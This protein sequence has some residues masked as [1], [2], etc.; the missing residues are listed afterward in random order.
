MTVME[1][2]SIIKVILAQEPKC[3]YIEFND[4][5]LEKL[6]LHDVTYILCYRGLYS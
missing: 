5:L 3:I 2:K 1:S 6:S 4:M